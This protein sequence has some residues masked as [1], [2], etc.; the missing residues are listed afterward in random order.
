MPVFG[1]EDL[2]AEAVDDDESRPAMT[3]I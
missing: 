1:T 3:E 2:L